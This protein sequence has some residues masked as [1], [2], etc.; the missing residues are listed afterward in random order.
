MDRSIYFIQSLLLFSLIKTSISIRKP[1]YMTELIVYCREDTYRF[2][3]LNQSWT[4]LLTCN[5]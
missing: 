5:V 2:K 1:A 3:A 4:T